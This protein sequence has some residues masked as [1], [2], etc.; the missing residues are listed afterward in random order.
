MRRKKLTVKRKAHTRTLKS[1]KKI[2]IKGST[3]KIKDIGKLGKVKPFPTKGKKK[4][5]LGGKGFVKKSFSAQ[6]AEIRNAKRKGFSNADVNRAI[7]RISVNGAYCPPERKKS[8]VQKERKVQLIT[9]SKKYYKKEV[10]K[11]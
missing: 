5:I 2:K 6:K 1:G 3:F 7:A 10:I 9:Y 8:C 11:R 4:K